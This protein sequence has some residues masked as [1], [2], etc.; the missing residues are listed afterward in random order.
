MTLKRMIEEKAKT[1]ADKAV[2]VYQKQRISYSELNQKANRI[3][4]GLTKLG[5][6]KGDRVALLLFNS[7][8]F[9]ISYFG[10][11]KT[12][13][14]AAPMNTAYSPEAMDY[15]LRISEPK[16]LIVD[17][18]LLDQ[19]VPNLP[20]WPF[21]QNIVQVNDE[22]TEF[23][24]FQRMLDDNPPTDLPF[25]PEPDLSAQIIY[26]SG[27]TGM[28]KGIE[29]SQEGVYT[30]GLDMA[31]AYLQTEADILPIFGLPLF[32]GAGL[33]QLLLGT[34]AVGGTSIIILG[35]GIEKLME[36]IS[37]EK[38]S[39]LMGLPWVYDAMASMSEAELR[40][41]DCSSLHTCITAGAPMP[42][43][44]VNRFKQRFGM[45]II[46]AY[47]CTE[48]LAIVSI[49][50]L[51]GSGKPGSVGKVLENYTFRLVD[52][53]D[54]PLPP[55]QIGEICLQGTSTFKGYFGN[56]H[57]TKEALRGDWLYTADLGKL[58]EEGNLYIMGRKQDII[59]V[60]GQRL[61]ASDIDAVLYAFP[62]VTDAAVVGIPDPDKGE[63]VKA[64]LVLKKGVKATEEEIIR[65][66]HGKLPSNA[67]PGQVEFR[68]SMP[69][70]PS[71]K[72]RRFQLK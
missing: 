57:A 66:C 19:V 20:Q 7:P 64:V 38:C 26:T 71:G 41:Y 59:I 23:I 48:A 52:D 40:K 13:A 30:G 65:F 28:P 9:A 68:D 53:D 3:A 67:I 37:E 12:G 6:Q 55:N 45:D 43:A 69:R 32:H 22:T 54:K 61:Y 44:I 51:D 60:A 4:H 49:Q 33:V 42:A 62:G 70:T 16:I 39:I 47:C 17:S 5:I 34:M 56:P 72:I 11:I 15:T 2:I 29:A 8:E 24:S 31:K 18:S 35:N 25:D 63:I 46:S 58:D 21:I 14:I 1:H 50:P 10:I 27:T 36:A